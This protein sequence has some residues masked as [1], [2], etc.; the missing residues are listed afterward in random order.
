MCI[1]SCH[2]LRI[3]S[4]TASASLTSDGGEWFFAKSQVSVQTGILCTDPVRCHMSTWTYV[5]SLDTPKHWQPLSFSDHTLLYSLKK[6]LCEEHQ[7]VIV[8][9]ITRDFYFMVCVQ[10]V[11]TDVLFMFQAWYETSARS[12][13]IFNILPPFSWMTTTLYKYHQMFAIWSTWTVW[14]CPPINSAAYLQNLVIWLSCVSSCSTIINS[15]LCLMNWAS[16]SSYNILVSCGRDYWFWKI[17][18]ISYWRQ[19]SL[20]LWLTM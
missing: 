2:W 11:W 9:Q 19:F 3:G 14:I 16:F 18:F 17:F 10:V 12:F 20:M 6:S 4:G 1:I 8:Q 5:C 13:F 7:I 15:G